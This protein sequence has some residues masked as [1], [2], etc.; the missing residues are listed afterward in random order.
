MIG[1]TSLN[2]PLK[3]YLTK[4]LQK[5]YGN[6]HTVSRVSWLGKYVIDILDKQYRK[7]TMPFK[8]TSFYRLDVPLS[9]IKESG[10][11]I[12][13]VKLK[14]LEEMI[15]KVFRNDLYSYIEV[16]VSSD[17]KFYN[18]VYQ[19][20]NKQNKMKAIAQFLK[21]YGINEDELSI[22]SLYRDFNRNT[23]H[24]KVLQP[25]KKDVVNT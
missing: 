24:D 2:I 9:I 25:I 7:K 16:S 18:E 13:I 11:D 4:Y 23:L 8:N 14:N 17:L 15:E 20:D 21:F 1:T 6:S 3:P 12:S 10:F 22:D 5:K 19:S